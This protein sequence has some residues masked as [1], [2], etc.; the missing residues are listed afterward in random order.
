MKAILN[1]MLVSGMMFLVAP[2][3]SQCNILNQLYPDGSM[4]YYIEPVNFYWTKAKSLKGGIETDKENYFLELQPVPFPE[5]DQGKKLRDDLEMN[6]SNGNIY[7]LKHFDTRYLDN[8]TAM[9][10][11]YFIDKEKLNDF[12]NL[13]VVSVKI[14]M[15]GTEG[16]RTY[17]FKLHKS[18][19][20]EQLSCFLK[21]QEEK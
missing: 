7:H 21:E 3:F 20:R 13:E 18:A 19:L 6:L 9:Q 10:L 1:C 5:K 11:L 15:K 16:V 8:D 17:V 2:A 12:L 4:Y 14:N